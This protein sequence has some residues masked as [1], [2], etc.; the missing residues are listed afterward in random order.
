[1]FMRKAALPDVLEPRSLGD[2]GMGLVFT[3]LFQLA[4]L[5]STLGTESRSRV[6]AQ[7]WT[8]LFLRLQTEPQG[9]RIKPGNVS[10]QILYDVHL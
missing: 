8:L 4:I 7:F 2:S 6:A 9:M 1:M 10:P 5:V 3:F